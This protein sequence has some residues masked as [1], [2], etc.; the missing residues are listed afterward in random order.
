MALSD[1]A[2]RLLGFP[3][4][5]FDGQ[6]SNPINATNPSAAALAQPT[7]QQ[8]QQQDMQD[9]GMQRIGQLGM[10]L[11][12]AGQRMTPKERA[13]I[14][15]QAPQYMDGMQR[16]AMTAAQARLMNMQGQA[17]QDE[18]TRTEALRQKFNDPS[19]LNSIGLSPEQAQALGPAGIQKLLENQALANTPDNI[20]DRQVKQT[21]LEA[22]RK[23][24]NANPYADATARNQAE[25]DGR[26]QQA[27][28]LGL[29]GDERKEFLA[30]G[31]LSGAGSAPTQD[32][33]NAATFYTMMQTAEKQLSDPK[34]GTVAA[35]RTERAIDALPFGMGRGFTSPEYQLAENAQR[36]F[37]AAYL[38]KT[39][40]QNITD[41]EFN[42]HKP[43]FFPQ[44]GETD[45]RV[46]SQKT[47]NRADAMKGIL[48]SAPIKFQR[49][50]GDTQ[51]QIQQQSGIP[52]V[53][54]I[55]Q[56]Q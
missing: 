21:Q 49:E 36:N 29:Q 55:R 16:D 31:R 50:V 56:I 12:A 52:G 19:Y 38:R 25:L 46:L 32:Q 4:Q 37:V 43:L 39:S 41:S 1:F 17:A 35:D 51:Q 6:S 53:R 28:Q 10:I 47:Q 15:A 13:T 40:G 14:L 7:M 54:S 9:A 30:N 45:P 22:A 48:G 42:M 33:A 2:Q 5:L 23:S 27:E 26:V 34:I 20:L 3:A 18:L 24:L 44:P 11:M 8:L